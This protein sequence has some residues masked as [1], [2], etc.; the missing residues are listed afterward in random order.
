MRFLFFDID[1][2]LNKSADWKIRSYS[3]DDA[4]I[5]MFCDFVRKNKLT[6]VMT[7]S[8]R[9]GF[10]GTLSSENSPQIRELESKFQ[11][12]GVKIYD[13]TPVAK[14]H[15]R[16]EEIAY[17]CRRHANEGYLI[18]DDDPEEYKVTDEH[19]FFTDSAKGITKDVVKSMERHLNA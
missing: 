9:T 17:Y 8:W 13:K 5:K 16:D 1:G 10:V 2:V 12:Y 11:Q 4:L 15:S 19:N 18:L 6:P 14:G 7:S 3:M